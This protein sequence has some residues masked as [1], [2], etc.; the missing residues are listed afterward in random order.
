MN[1]MARRRFLRRLP[2]EE[3]ETVSASPR[4]CSA[5]TLSVFYGLLHK[6]D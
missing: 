4:I 6:L 1:F 5:C 3:A 2:A